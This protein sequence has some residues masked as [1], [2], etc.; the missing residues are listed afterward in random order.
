MTYE[1]LD[2]V[3][4]VR[5]LPEHSLRAGDIGA[6]VELYDDALEVDFVTGDGRTQ[7]LLTLRVEEVRPIAEREIL[8]V[9]PL[10]ASA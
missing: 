2:T 5:D 10:A 8:A 4:L 7:A 3:V 9:R 1:L 6:V